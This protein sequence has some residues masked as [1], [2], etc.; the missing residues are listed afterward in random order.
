MTQSDILTTLDWWFII[1]VLGASVLPV[2]I[3]IFKPFFDKGYIFAKLLGL[4]VTSYLVFFLSVVHIVHFGLGSIG[5][6]AVLL[7]ICSYFLLLQKKELLETMKAHVNLFLFEEVLFLAVLFFWAYIH[8]FNPDIHGLEKYM[9]FGFLNSILRADYFPPKDMWFTPFPINYYYFGHL[10][11]A[12]L[13]KLSGLSSS[14]T[15]NLMLATIAAWC[16]SAVF[17]IATTLAS[18]LDKQKRFSYWKRILAGLLSATLVTFAGNL[19]ILYVFFIPYANEAPQ[20]LWELVFNPSGFPNNYWYPNA[21]R[22]IYHTIHE[23]PIYSWVVA[24]LHGHV[25]DIPFVLLTIAVLLSLFLTFQINPKNK[26][27]K[28]ITVLNI[29][30]LKLF[31]IWDFEF[32]YLPFI[33]FLLAIMYMTNAWDGPIYLLLSLFVFITLFWGKTTEHLK[34]I[35][36]SF[37]I[38]LASF[39][40]FSLPYNFFFK[41]FASGIGILCAPNFLTNIGHI[42]P[43]LFEKDHCIHSLWWQLLLLYGFF[44][45]FVIFFLIFIAKTRKLLRTDLFV[46]LLIFLASILIILPEFIYLKDI[47]PAHYRANTMFKLVFQAFILLSISSGYIIIRILTS[48]RR[49][50]AIIYL[51]FVIVLVSFVLIYPYLAIKSYY[52]LETYHGLVGTTYLKTLYP[53]DYDAIEWL[54]MN[55]KGQPVILEAQGD[56]YTDFA[57]V[58]TSTGLPTV[59]GWTVHEWLWRGTYDVP[60]PRIEEVRI[61]YE[62]PNSAQAQALLKKY[63]VKYVFI[64]TLEYQKYPTLQEEQFAKFGKVVFQE[65]S[66]KIYQ[67][68]L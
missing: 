22:F 34:S 36:A 16:F 51:P 38:V 61:M 26:I 50:I 17:S 21:T 11:T 42:G 66:T 4:A 52:G 1:F 39:L 48:V 20:P 63:H 49:I 5:G 30:N 3:L 65:G 67:L 59:L 44:Y 12:V 7:A 9:D 29:K 47:Y 40:L 10:M 8:G 58:S 68:N 41:P 18:F 28:N 31:K 45:F 56:S 13:T 14:V 35:L 55:V 15:F 62:E 57:R 54:K 37:F 53:S 43:F 27:S 23:F 24:D 2:T 46:L 25:L 60:A 33:G 6:V 32:C 19:H 64:G